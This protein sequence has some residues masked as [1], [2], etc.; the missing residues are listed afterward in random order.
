MSLED[1]IVEILA[2]LINALHYRHSRTFDTNVSRVEG[3]ED[4]MFATRNHFHC[5]APHISRPPPSRRS[6][7][8]DSP[9]PK[10]DNGLRNESPSARH[11]QKHNGGGPS[12]KQTKE[13]ERNQDGGKYLLRH[14]W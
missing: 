9:S 14:G 1:C 10:G 2:L 3:P 13:R 7:G 8:D 11:H 4:S 12:G 6:R 5:G